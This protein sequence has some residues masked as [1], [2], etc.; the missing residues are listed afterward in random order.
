MSTYLAI[1]V[2][3][4]LGTYL[5]RLSF[6]AAFARSGVPA[7]LEAPLRYVAPAVLAALVAPAVI[8]P[9][10]MVDVSSGNPRFFAGLLALVV[11]LWTKS[12]PWTIFAGMASLWLFQAL[13]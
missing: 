12:V 4:G 13:F 10:G 3:V 9:G 1:I 8:A 7:W 2:V 6:V 11:A 5:T